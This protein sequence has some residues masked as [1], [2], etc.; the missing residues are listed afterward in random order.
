MN[1]DHAGFKKSILGELT[2]CGTVVIGGFTEK[3]SPIFCSLEQGQEALLEH[4]VQAR[5]GV[6]SG[7][8]AAS[9]I[10]LCPRNPRPTEHRTQGGCTLTGSSSLSLAFVDA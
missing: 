3:R 9:L 4:L 5:H 6:G 7:A 1:G 10:E 2:A 8:R